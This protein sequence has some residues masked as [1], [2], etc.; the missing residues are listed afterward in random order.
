M[1]GKDGTTKPVL[2]LPAVFRPHKSA[3]EEAKEKVN[4]HIATYSNINEAVRSQLPI[5]YQQQ[6]THIHPNKPIIWTPPN[7]KD[8]NA[9]TKEEESIPQAARLL[10][11][12]YGEA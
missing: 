1:V 5:P 8:W 3:E 11:L 6:A 12:K 9:D 7:A 10:G 4:V 2:R